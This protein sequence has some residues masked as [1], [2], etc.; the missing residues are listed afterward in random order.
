MTY[1][2]VYH[3]GATLYDPDKCFNGYTIFQAKE[4]GAMLIDMNGAEVKLWKGLHG[5]PNKIFPGGYVLGHT[6]ERPNAYGMQDQADLVQVDFDGKIVWEYISPYLGSMI[7]MNMVYR[8]P[9]ERV[10]QLDIPKQT[11]IA[12][13]DV[14]TYRV[15]GAAQ[16]GPR[17]VTAVEGVRPYQGDAAPCV[18]VDKD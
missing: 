13:I 16:S 11:S 17:A 14:T 15:P 12:P 3:T 2:S 4:V 18:V 1:P 5:F 9:Y 7:K 10:P 8:V 6:G